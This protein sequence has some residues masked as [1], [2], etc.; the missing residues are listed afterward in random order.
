MKLFYSYMWRLFA[1][2]STL[3]KVVQIPLKIFSPAN[4]WHGL[5]MPGRC[6][7]LVFCFISFS[8]NDARPQ[9]PEKSGA[10]S[11]SEI[12]PLK[13]G[14]QIPDELWNLP[15]QVVNHPNGKET[16]TL[17]EYKGK[18]I[19]LDFWA[20]WC[21]TCVKGSPLVDSIQNQLRDH[22]QFVLNNPK[23]TFDDKEKIINAIK[24][25]KDTYKIK[26]DI[27]STYLDTTFIG[28]FELFSYP[29]IIWI[30]KNKKVIAITG[31]RDLTYENV[32]KYINEGYITL[33]VK[34]GRRDQ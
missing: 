22:V 28:H 21:G 17:S 23:R 25:A 15:L 12:K 29:H 2:I 33:P 7:F 27:P 19:I 18:L 11:G 16:I 5:V 32:S 20:T 34:P 10:G 31:K 13:I 9:S 1:H 3:S 8:L 6:L 14:D 30:G 4:Q 24:L 26:F